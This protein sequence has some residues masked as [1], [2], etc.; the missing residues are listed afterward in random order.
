MPDRRLTRG[1]APAAQAVA[2]AALGVVIVWMMYLARD[3]LLLI[4]VSVLLAIGFGPVVHAIEHQQVVPV[5]K[6]LPRWLA[7]LIVY[8]LIVGTITVVGFLVIPPLLMAAFRHAFA[9][10]AVGTVALHPKVN[11]R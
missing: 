6:R 8:V 11:T 2:V 9:G 4:Y 1:F 10:M 5:G 3:V 7:I